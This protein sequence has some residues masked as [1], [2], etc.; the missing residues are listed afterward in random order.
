MG[1]S[2]ILRTY[3]DLLQL[4]NP[5]LR[6]F[7]LGDTDSEVIFYL[8][9]S[10]LSRHGPLGRRHGIETVMDAMEETVRQIREIADVPGLEKNALLTLLATNGTT[11]VAT[12]G[13]KDLYWSTYKNRCADR[14]SCSYF[15][16]ECEA[17][18]ETGFINHLIF[19]SEPLSGENVWV[20]MVPGE[21]IGVD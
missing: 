3:A 21:T 9:L 5:H 17:P 6:R 13:G 19:S 8:F 15:A 7:I 12:Q 20:P 1:I 16:A 10:E 18:S 4:I 2:R 14:D 11:M